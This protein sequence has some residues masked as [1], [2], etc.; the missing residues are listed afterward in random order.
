MPTRTSLKAWRA[1]PQPFLFSEARAGG[2]SGKAVVAASSRGDLARLA[3]GLYV[4]VQEWEGLSEIE[5]HLALC[6]AALAAVPGAVVS[7]ASAAVLH[8]LPKPTGPLGKVSLVSQT[9]CQLT[10]SPDDWKRVLHGGLA[11]QDWQ[12]KHGL[13]VTVPART[14]ADCIRTLGLRNG[15]AIADAAVRQQLMVADDLLAARMQQRRWPGATNIDVALALL[16]GRRESWLESASVVVA[17]RN[18]YSKPLSQVTI[19]T[20]EGAFV[21]RAD[22]LWHRGGVIGEADGLGKYRGDFDAAGLS[23][24]DMAARVIAERDRE[25]ALEALGFGV[26]RW[27]NKDLWNGGD[28]LV[29]SLREARRR[30][31]PSGIHCLWK[32]EEDE[33]LRPWSDLAEYLVSSAA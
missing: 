13:L 8:G 26:A 24:D 3:E 21:G 29:R 30:A 19:H 31:R 16:D 10:S 1:L 9:E 18:G 5:Q 20:P 32:L 14:A 22:F 2:F 23:V 33:Q 11:R 4:L 7:H 6:R 25:R 12:E 28:G 15:L 27:G 17:F